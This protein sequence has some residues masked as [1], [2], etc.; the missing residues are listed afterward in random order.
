MDDIGIVSEVQ[1]QMKWKVGRTSAAI[2]SAAVLCMWSML[3]HQKYHIPATN[4]DEFVKL[5]LRLV[6]DEVILTRVTSA[7][8]LTLTFRQWENVDRKM[9][10][11]FTTL[12]GRADDI[13]REVRREALLALESIFITS[14]KFGDPFREKFNKLLGTLSLDEDLSTRQTAEGNF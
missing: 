14:G 5:V 6:E 7:R 3:Q 11:V 12:A 9:D 8:I 4:L 13:S 1:K 2:R 10:D